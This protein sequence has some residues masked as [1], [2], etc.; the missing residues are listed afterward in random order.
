MST[1]VQKLTEFVFLFAAKLYSVRGDLVADM[2]V[3]EQFLSYMMS[4]SV[5]TILEKSAILRV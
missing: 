3:D 4:K 2:K 1:F 5:I